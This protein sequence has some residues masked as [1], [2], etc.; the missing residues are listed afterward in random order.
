MARRRTVSG[1]GDLSSDR[2]PADELP[3]LAEAKLAAPRLRAGMVQRPR[4]MRALDAGA[5]AALTLVAAP[6]GYGKTTAVRTWCAHSETALAWVTLD[7]GDNDSSRFWTYIA[8]AVDRI[9]DGLGR[10]ALHKIGASGMPIEAAVDELMNGVAAF[11]DQLTLV[12]DDFQTVTN[13]RCLASI[14][15]AVARLPTAARLIVITRVDP[16]LQLGG[17]RASGS[18]LELRASDLA[19]TSAEARELLVDHGG[20]RL[21]A[22]DVDVLVRRTEGWPAA[23]YLAALWLR[24]VDDQR[25]AVQEFGGDLRYVA[26]YLSHEV[27]AALVPEEHAFLLKAAV[28]GRFTAELCDSVLGREDSAAMLDDLENSNMFVVRLERQDWF[29]VHP[30]FAQFATARLVAVDPGAAV[31]IHR[32]AAAWFRSHGLVVEAVEHASAAGDHAVV[33]ELL[34]E[35]HLALLRKGRAA[36][37][38]RWTQTLPDD[39]LTVYPELAAASATAA[40]VVG[41]HTLERR[42]L[43]ELARRAKT[44]RPERFSRHADATMAMVHAS[45]GDVGVSEAVRAGRRAV[46]LA[47]DGADDVFVAACASLA[48][49]L[50]FAGSL[51]EAWRAASRAVAHPDAPRRPP[52]YAL[53]QSILAVVAVE[54][55]RLTA[56]RSHAEQARAIV[57]GITSSRSWLGANAAVAVG[58]VLAAEGDLPGAEREFVYAERF[59]HDEVATVDHARLLV[60]LADVRCRR[61]RF[62]EADMTLRRAREE[63]AELADSGIVQS[64]AEHVARQLAEARGHARQGEILD[65]P[66]DAELGVLQLL[67]TDLSTRQIAQQLFL[68]PNTVRSHTRS[69][70]RKLGVNS[71]ENAVA[72]ATALGLMDEAQSPR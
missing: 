47:E 70:Y 38:L 37:L 50:Y 41:Q 31:Q 43:L 35:Y 5:D 59:F 49:A 23:L 6:A 65:S 62:D 2:R 30:L 61:G 40:T 52:G 19:F 29:R 67:M 21:D 9:R 66:S 34:S 55:G 1:A 63:L 64:L 60:R 68:S 17:L 71:R 28:L 36:T 22:E 53:A 26:E 48:R 58:A 25:L 51:D 13:D 8:T 54:G 4:V 18:L 24:T 45:A 72:R 33:A 7:A 69:I 27:L 15:H 3:P 16:A 56:G 10:R 46:E 11:A 44:N 32:R 39:T 42:R 57:G 14:A 20:L 12:L